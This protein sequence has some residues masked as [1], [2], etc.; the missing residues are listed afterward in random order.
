MTQPLNAFLKGLDLVRTNK[1]VLFSKPP[2]R[3][4]VKAW[5]TVLR[6]RI[7]TGGSLSSLCLCKGLLCRM[8]CH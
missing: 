7:V 5:L 3:V 8:H 6:P 1:Y 2:L 4:N